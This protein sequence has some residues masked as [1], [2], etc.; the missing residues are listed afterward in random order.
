MGGSHGLLR[1]EKALV[2]GTLVAVAGLLLQAASG[3]IPVHAN[4]GSGSRTVLSEQTGPYYL[5]VIAEPG[6]PR[7]GSVHLTFVL[8]DR[9]RTASIRDAA[10]AIEVTPP[11]DSGLETIS[12]LVSQS[13]S[14]PDNYDVTLPVEAVGDWGI[15]VS[16][17]GALGQAETSL[18]LSVTARDSAIFT[19]LIVT[20][21]FPTFLIVLWV[22]LRWRRSRQPTD[23]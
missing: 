13:Q 5:I 17:E 19:I 9:E 3:P 16:V 10:I 23:A 20:L 11:Q 2:I 18:V 4:G 21:A 12:Y 8:M 14:N 6:R 7:V 1:P 15:E 22:W